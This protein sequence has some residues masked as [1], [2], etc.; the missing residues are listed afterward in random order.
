M[1]SL[2]P[3][4]LAVLVY[5]SSALGLT[6]GAQQA[7]SLSG[8][9][10]ATPPAQHTPV[11][12]PVTYPGATE[13]MAYYAERSSGDSAPYNSLNRAAQ[14][15]TTVIPF[16]YRVDAQG[17]VSGR[18]NQKMLNLAR[19]R[20]LKVLALVHNA[21]SGGFD[22]RLVHAFLANPLARSR[23]IDGL[24]ALLVQTGLDGIN[25]DLERIPPGDR[26]NLVAFVRDL[27]PG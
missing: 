26:W 3:T 10:S 24:F 22:S 7:P 16:A 4:L 5:L 1:Q 18:V 9:Y 12:P 19:A 2:W 11:A 21:G 6:P 17:H 20:G 8:G 27:P 23:A 14:A 25:L 13:V 15:M